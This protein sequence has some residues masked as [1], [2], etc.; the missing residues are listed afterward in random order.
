MPRH[1]KSVACYSGHYFVEKLAHTS[2]LDS[3]YHG[4][5]GEMGGLR[6][7]DTSSTSRH[8]LFHRAR[9]YGSMV[10][11]RVSGHPNKVLVFGA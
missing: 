10:K 1:D 7:A 11:E 6:S 8:Q 3:V 5:N 2:I 4:Y 9:I